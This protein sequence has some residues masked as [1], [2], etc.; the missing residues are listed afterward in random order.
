M[1]Y[2]FQR[3]FSKPLLS[4][5]SHL[6]VTLTASDDGYIKLPVCVYVCVFFLRSV[7]SK[8]SVREG[9]WNNIRLPETVKPLQYNIHIRTDLTDFKFNGTVEIRIECKQEVHVLL[10]HCILLPQSITLHPDED[11][12]KLIHFKNT[13]WIHEENQYL[14]L[15][16]EEPLRV[17]IT[18]T[19]LAMFSSPLLHDFNAGYFR[20]PYETSGGNR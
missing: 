5:V 10:L 18:Y 8:S 4:I 1:F 12:N 16:L 14:V 15:E 6:H 19:F 20:T 3:L 9:I 13:P 11:K 2:K 7:S 17:G